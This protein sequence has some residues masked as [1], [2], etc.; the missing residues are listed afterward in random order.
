MLTLYKLREYIVYPGKI[1]D[2]PLNI[3]YH[4]IN[5]I[6]IGIYKYKGSHHQFIGLYLKFHDI[7]YECINNT[8]N[9]G[10]DLV[11]IEVKYSRINDEL[12][13]ITKIVN[14]ELKH[15]DITIRSKKPK[16]SLPVW[17]G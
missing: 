11:E 14:G 6:T 9:L 17:H 3:R 16:F 7:I 15:Q 2:R 1:D 4:Q 5:Q 12:I 8:D 13:L 10:N